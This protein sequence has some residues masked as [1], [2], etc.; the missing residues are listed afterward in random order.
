MGLRFFLYE[1]IYDEVF[2]KLLV[3]F[4]VMVVGDL[5]DEV[6]DMGVIINVS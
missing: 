6:S 1:D 5:F 4:G 3:K 2:G